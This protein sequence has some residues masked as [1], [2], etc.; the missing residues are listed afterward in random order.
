MTNV[1]NDH[2]ELKATAATW[3]AAGAVVHV[4]PSMS[5]PV[6][7]Q[8]PTWARNASSPFFYGTSRAFFYGASRGVSFP[9]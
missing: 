1:A 3:M 5:R 8:A 6:R 2:L 7:L 9:L 4:A